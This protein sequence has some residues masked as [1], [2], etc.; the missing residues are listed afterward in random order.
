MIYVLLTLLVAPLLF[1]RLALRRGPAEPQRILV[2]QTAKI[3]DF[4]STTPLLREIKRALPQAQLAVLLHPVN[5]PLARHNPHIDELLPLRPEGLRGLRGRIWLMRILSRRRIDTVVCASPSLA[6][7]TAPFWAGVARRMSVLPNYAGA[8]YRV[9]RPLLTHAEPHRAG[10]RVIETQAA[11]LAQIGIRVQSLMTEA[12]A[13]PS[14]EQAA[15]RIVPQDSR[16]TVG[17]GVSAG[18]KLKEL[19]EERL[20]ELARGILESSEVRLVLIG[21]PDDRRLVEQVIA[22]LPPERVVDAVGALGLDQ[23]PALLA[24]LDAYVGVD[25]GITYLADACGV[26][27][28]DLMGPADADDQRPGG[29]RA[30]VLRSD[31]PCAPCSHAFKAP[32]H[33]AIGTRACIRGVA[34]DTVARA[35]VDL[36]KS[37][38]R[39]A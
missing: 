12:F 29:P 8:T 21:G 7:W 4:V 14:A 33:C 26:A 16:P 5:L 39:R 9:A 19:G 6:A 3:G 10:R 17:I 24:R 28:V 31:L 18:N 13:A 23:L 22:H 36:L 32:Y 1:L 27:V 30:V 25:S 2:I 15:E 34:L 37:G 11:L 38:A 20:L 35:V